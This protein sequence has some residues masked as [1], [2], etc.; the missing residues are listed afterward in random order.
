MAWEVVNGWA[1]LFEIDY[2]KSSL[3]TYSF[4][5]LRLWMAGPVERD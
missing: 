5:W 2:N 3:F 1:D 4:P